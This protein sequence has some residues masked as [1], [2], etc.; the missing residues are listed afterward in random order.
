MS[1]HFRND[2][3]QNSAAASGALSISAAVAAIGS[4]KPSSQAAPPERVRVLLLTPKVAAAVRPPEGG[5]GRGRFAG[6]IH[7]PRAATTRNPTLLFRWSGVFRLRFAERQFLPWLFQLPPRTVR[8][9]ALAAPRGLGKRFAVD[10]QAGQ[11]H[12]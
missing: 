9:V 1:R 12:T 4:G 8:S 10:N 7:S 3:G 2:G 6:D 5:P 11:S